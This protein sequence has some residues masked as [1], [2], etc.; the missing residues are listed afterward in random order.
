MNNQDIHRFSYLHPLGGLR[1]A[2]FILAGADLQ[3]RVFDE[4]RPRTIE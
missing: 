2:F 1:E 3:S 4:Q